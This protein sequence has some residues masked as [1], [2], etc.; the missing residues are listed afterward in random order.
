MLARNEIIFKW[1]LYALAAALCFFVQGAVFQ[2]LTIWGVIPFVFPLVAAIPATYER[3][4][5]GTLFALAV[6]VVC[7]LLLPGPIPCFY[8]LVFPLVGLCASLMAQSLLPAGYLCSLAAAAAAFLM[9]DLFHCLLLAMRGKLV[10]STWAAL[11]LRE[12]CV[13]L[14]LA[15]PATWL[16]RAVYRK[17]HFDD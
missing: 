17:T 5:S 13:T 9:T 4:V 1:V 3:A 15:L 6:G 8:T 7:D 14:P 11:S 12:F 10:W 2:R 16:F